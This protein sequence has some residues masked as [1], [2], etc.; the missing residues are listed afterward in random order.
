[1]LA[2]TCIMIFV[3]INMYDSQKKN[4][5]V[6]Y[7]LYVGSKAPFIHHRVIVGQR[8]KACDLVIIIIIGVVA[9][10]AAHL[11]AFAFNIYFAGILASF[12]YPI[13]SAL[14]SYPLSYSLARHF[15]FYDFVC[16]RLLRHRGDVA[17]NVWLS[18]LLRYTV[19]NPDVHMCRL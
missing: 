16:I 14:S 18:S 13:I 19:L 17:P 5:S 1:M 8:Q 6:A 3:H 15:F 12:P 2:R 10:A 4:R 9:C 11:M 7:L